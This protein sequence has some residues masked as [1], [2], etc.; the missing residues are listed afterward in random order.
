[1]LVRESLSF[2]IGVDAILESFVVNVN[3]KLSGS[4]FVTFVFM[5][6]Q[7][8]IQ[9]HIGRGILT[10]HDQVFLVNVAAKLK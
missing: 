6:Y 1:M 2:P 5:L 9:T 3:V 8:V 7:F 4:V 10:G